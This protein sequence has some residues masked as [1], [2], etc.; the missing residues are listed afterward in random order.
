MEYKKI[1][2][3]YVELIKMANLYY[4]MV[5][6]DLDKDIPEDVKTKHSKKYNQLM[7]D[8]SEALKK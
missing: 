6:V 5:L 3:N 4:D 2:A 7:I 1:C 8:M